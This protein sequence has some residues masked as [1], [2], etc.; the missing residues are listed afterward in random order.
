[1]DATEKSVS[2]KS[3]PDRGQAAAGGGKLGRQA[4]DWA[5]ARIRGALHA[6]LKRAVA[7]FSTAD[8][9]PFVHAV[10]RAGAKQIDAT[11]SPGCTSVLLSR[12]HRHARCYVPPSACP[13]A[14]PILRLGF[15]DMQRAVA[16]DWK[17]LE[18]AAAFLR[19]GPMSAATSFSAAFNRP[20]HASTTCGSSSGGVSSTMI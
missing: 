11:C 13:G 1:M 18:L 10:E 5:S 3:Y 7:V 15:Q 20:I 16:I 8:R 9:S 14:P 2:W 4:S 6:H 19:V 12:P 17:T